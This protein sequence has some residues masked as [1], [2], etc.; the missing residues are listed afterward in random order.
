[1]TEILKLHDKDSKAALK[2]LQQQIKNM[3]ETIFYQISVRKWKA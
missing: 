1:M 2:M 3:L